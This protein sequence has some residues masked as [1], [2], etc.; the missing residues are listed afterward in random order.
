MADPPL[1]VRRRPGTSGSWASDETLNASTCGYRKSHP[2]PGADAAMG[3]PDAGMTD[4]VK[5]LGG[6]LVGLFRSRAAGEAARAFLRQ[7]LLVLKRSA[8][9][10][11]SLRTAD[12]LIFVWLCRAG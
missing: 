10:R 7:Q 9:A 4:L 3:Y 5:L 6:F 1:G 12:R 2:V 11:L 8:P